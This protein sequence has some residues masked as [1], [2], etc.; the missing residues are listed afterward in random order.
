M[1]KE[2]NNTHI[3]YD[4][5]NEEAPSFELSIFELSTPL[6]SVKVT[7]HVYQIKLLWIVW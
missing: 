6:H 1:K 5:A 4:E 2:P 3:L 7:L